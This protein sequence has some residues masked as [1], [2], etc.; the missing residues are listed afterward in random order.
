MRYSLSEILKKAS[1]IPDIEER[2]AYLRS[3][4]SHA[5]RQVF[6]YALNPNVK[7][8]LPKGNPPYAPSKFPDAY[9]VLYAEIR[10]LYLFVEGGNNDLKPLRRE[11]LF[12]ELLENVYPEDALLLLAMKDGKLPYPGF[13]PNFVR[14]TFPGLLPPPEKKEEVTVE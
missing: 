11:A 3:N 5:L 4:D 1:E 13:S 7:W 10:K 14:T 9:T 6:F 2:R 8:L 12:I